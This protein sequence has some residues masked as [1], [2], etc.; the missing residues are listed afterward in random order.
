MEKEP[1]LSSLL[2]HNKHGNYRLLFVLFL[3]TS[4]V[5]SMHSY[6][7]PVTSSNAAGSA[8]VLSKT[9]K[10]LWAGGSFRVKVKKNNA[11]KLLGTSWSLDKSGKEA[12]ILS[13][14]GR[15]YALVSSR[16]SIKAG[17]ITAHLYAKVSYRVGKKTKTKK[18]TC[19]ITIKTPTSD[20]TELPTET[21]VP[22]STGV[23]PPPT[24]LI[25]PTPV[26]GT[27]QAPTVAPTATPTPVTSLNVVSSYTKVYVEQEKYHTI[28]SVGFNK[29]YV[30]QLA[31]DS[32]PSSGDPTNT[33]IGYWTVNVARVA[34]VYRVQDKKFYEVGVNRIIRPARTGNYDK[35]LI[36]LNTDRYEG[37]YMIYLY[38]F[39]ADGTSEPAID[40]SISIE[41]KL[42]DIVAATGRYHIVDRVSEINAT[43]DVTLTIGGWSKRV[44]NQTQSLVSQAELKKHVYV[45]D[46]SGYRLSVNNI[47]MD[48][49]NNEITIYVEGGTESTWFVV[50]FDT[51]AP[52]MLWQLDDDGIYVA[53]DYYR[54]TTVG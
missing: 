24:G 25:P 41:L 43:H 17:S 45:T 39:R 44:V 11:K 53:R 30:Q 8:P 13:E 34:R 26:P 33:D 37:T 23:T 52:Y 42:L 12:L 51:V 46:S 14:T 9:S 29:N 31:Y 20:V 54:V 5:I 10:T 6:M 2:R 40:R 50:T 3:V 49:A 47:F 28:V 15:N 32:V 48:S 21:V 22:P 7:L 4:L 18:L 35:L 16:S 36:D 27:T 38:G 1:F 19:K